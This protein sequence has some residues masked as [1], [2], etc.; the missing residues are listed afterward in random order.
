MAAHIDYE[1]E[2][3]CVT[4]A[5]NDIDIQLSQCA[6]LCAMDRCAVEELSTRLQVVTIVKVC[7]Y[8]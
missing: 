6:D 1:M 5:V 3:S 7:Y 4:S 8:F 2:Y